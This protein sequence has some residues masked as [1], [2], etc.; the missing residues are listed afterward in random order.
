MLGGLC[1]ILKL[2]KTK[3]LERT[4][5]QDNIRTKI[6]LQRPQLDS[7]SVGYQKVRSTPTLPFLLPPKISRENFRGNYLPVGRQ[8]I[9]KYGSVFYLSPLVH[10]LHHRAPGT[11]QHSGSCE[12]SIAICLHMITHAD[13]FLKAENR[14]QSKNL[15]NTLSEMTFKRDNFSNFF[16]QKFLI[17]NI[18]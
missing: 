13:F 6:H 12:L 7:N 17:K 3:N 9:I 2:K 10:N 1:G 11:I 18:S 15:Q 8:I 4:F 14:P 16:D 5:Q